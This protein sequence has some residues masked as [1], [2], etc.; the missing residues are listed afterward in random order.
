MDRDSKI[1]DL[2]NTISDMY[3]FMR[4]AKPVEKIKSHAK[5]LAAIAKQIARRPPMR[6]QGLGGTGMGGGSVRPFGK[7]GLT[8]DHM[9]SQ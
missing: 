8:F 1:Q 7:S 4:E 3:A 9:L 5:V 2:I 6:A